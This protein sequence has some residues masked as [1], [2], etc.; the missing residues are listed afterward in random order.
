[1]ATS[2][3]ISNITVSQKI[4]EGTPERVLQFLR[5]TQFKPIYAILQQAG[6]GKDDHA[7][8]WRLLKSACGS[9]EITPMH[10][11]GAQA[12]KE[13]DAWDEGGFRRARAA[14][15][16]LHPEQMAFVFRGDLKASEGL[17]AVMGVLTFL[18]RLDELEKSPDR[19]S[20]RK[21]DKAALE[22]L[23]K[24]GI[25]DVERKR[26]R[27]LVDIVQKSP[28]MTGTEGQAEEA[29]QEALVELRAWFEDWSTTARSVVTRRDHMIRLGLAKRKS[30]GKIEDVDDTDGSDEDVSPTPS[31]VPPTPVTPQPIN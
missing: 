7:E 26:L 2:S 14:L 22:T 3:N 17:P 13:L 30:N 15:T 16:R 10:D 25:D 23:A 12:V 31:P 19:K 9:E 28:V 18:D 20:T 27:K 1:M 24:R 21:A 29:K 6:Y 4:L 8:G 5:G 11:E